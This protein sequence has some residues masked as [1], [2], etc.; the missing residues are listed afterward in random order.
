MTDCYYLKT[1]E[2]PLNEWAKL[3]SAFAE[4]YLA[5]DMKNESEQYMISQFK[6]AIGKIFSLADILKVLKIRILIFTHSGIFY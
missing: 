2:L 6:S 1:M 5:G 3:A 4:T